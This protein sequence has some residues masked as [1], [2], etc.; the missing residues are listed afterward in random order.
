MTRPKETKSLC[1]YSRVRS[2]E[3]HK[4]PLPWVHSPTL[5]RAIPDPG[6]VPPPVCECGDALGENERCEI[7]AAE[8]CRRNQPS[9]EHRMLQA[10]LKAMTVAGVD[11]TPDTVNA[12]LE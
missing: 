10:K 5:G 6:W 8:R 3:E 1:T 11:A 9:L 7:C 2:S 4:S 12:K